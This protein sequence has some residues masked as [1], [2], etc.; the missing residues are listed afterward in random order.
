MND[1]YYVFDGI[2]NKVQGMSKEQILNAI[3]EATGAT[4]ASV[5]DAFITT[6]KEIN[7]NH[8]LHIWKGTQAQYNAIQTPDNDTFYIIEDDVT[9]SDLTV[10][11]DEA[12]DKIDELQDLIGE[13]TGWQTLTVSGVDIGAYRI[14][15]KVLF[16]DVRYTA[17][18]FTNDT[19]VLPIH[20]DISRLISVDVGGTQGNLYCDIFETANGLQIRGWRWSESYTSYQIF[21]TLPAVLS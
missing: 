8:S 13:D 21:L 12:N 20:A 11:L 18:D 10:G 2:K 16:L 15:G 7:R 5:D 3:A 4:P 1:V 6:I 9:I 17:G 19:I 14:I